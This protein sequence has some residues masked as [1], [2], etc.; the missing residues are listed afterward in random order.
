MIAEPSMPPSLIGPIVRLADVHKY[1]GQL[2]VLK[3]ISFDVMA[4]EVICII[5]PSGSG[6]STLLR[7]INALTP[8]NSGSIQVKGQEVH[9]P[10]LDK[11][12][13]RKKVGMVFQQF[14]LLPNLSVLENLL[15]ASP[16]APWWQ[17]RRRRIMNDILVWLQKLAP[18]LDPNR[19]V[20]DLAVG[21]RQVVE[22]A[23]VLNLNPRVVILD[24]PTSALDAQAEHEIFQR[25]AELTQGRLTVFISHRFSTVRMADRIIVLQYGSVVEDGTHEQLLANDGLYARLYESQF[26][27][28]NHIVLSPTV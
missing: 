5:G 9:A 1:F 13:L 21:E 26:G 4:G 17:G 3:G 27:F 20:S 16:K 28:S 25:F 23:K 15:V 11:L 2:E 24:E 14:S 19:R 7:C 6:K 22:L 18:K 8:I 12:E 10:K